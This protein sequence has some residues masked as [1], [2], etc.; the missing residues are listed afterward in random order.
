MSRERRDL[1]SEV[2]HD[3]LALA[4]EQRAAFLTEACSGDDALRREVESLLA[5]ES[6]S[7]PFLELPAAGV[8][9][10]TTSVTSMIDRQLGPYRIVG[11]LGAGGMGEVYKALDTRLDRVVAVKVAG[12]R[13]SERFDREARAVALL[14]HP[15]ICQL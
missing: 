10:V 5:F 11:L 3:A 4:P 8:A 6:A 14:N 15:N 7:S 12:K 13:F 9:T 2:Y 1:I